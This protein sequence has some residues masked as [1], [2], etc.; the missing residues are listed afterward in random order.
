VIEEA[1]G[2][3]VATADAVSSNMS[4]VAGL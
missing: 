3:T 2:I 4:S 1:L